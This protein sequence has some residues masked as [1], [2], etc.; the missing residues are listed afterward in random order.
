L[1]GA[2]IRIS[3][4][5]LVNLMV[6]TKYN[7]YF[8][9]PIPAIIYKKAGSLPTDSSTPILPTFCAHFKLP[10]CLGAT[11]EM[12]KYN[13]NWLR[14]A[15]FIQGKLVPPEFRITNNHLKSD[16]DIIW[17]ADNGYKIPFL[18]REIIFTSCQILLFKWPNKNPLK[19]NYSEVRLIEVD[20]MPGHL[21]I[22]LNGG[23]F[24]YFNGSPYPFEALIQY[25]QHL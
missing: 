10:E 24:F 4:D 9:H 7:N 5:G 18:K 8:L 6:F 14:L 22:A 16:E 21:F 12:L 1:K 15:H 2:D 3:F 25:F 13:L 19:S 20:G 23:K 17:V 11:S